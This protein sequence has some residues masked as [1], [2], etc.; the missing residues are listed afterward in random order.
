MVSLGGTDQMD[1][2]TNHGIREVAGLRIALLK[3]ML[4][5]SELRRDVADLVLLV[6]C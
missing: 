3:Q 6:C 4:G 1:S 2:L 5:R